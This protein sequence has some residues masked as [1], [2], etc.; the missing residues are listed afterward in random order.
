MMQS[1][2]FNWSVATTLSLLLYG[3]VFLQRGAPV[4]IE[5]TAD[6]HSPL[7][8]RL[9]F[10]QIAQPIPDVLPVIEKPKLTPLVSKK[11]R[12]FKEIKK[13]RI[14]TKSRY[15]TANTKQTAYLFF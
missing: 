8:T 14:R 9:T 11:I 5:S 4:G 10:N 6:V 3:M 13:I 7:M 2:S 15:S 1:E 12:S